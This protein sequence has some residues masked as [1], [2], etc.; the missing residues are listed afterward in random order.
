MAMIKEDQSMHENQSWGF[1]NFDNLSKSKEKLIV[2]SYG[3][4]RE[5]L[6]NKKRSWHSA[7]GSG[8]KVS[9]AK[10]NDG[11]SLELDH[12]M[13]IQIE[14]ERSKKMRNMFDN[15]HALLPQLPSKVD[16]STIVDEAVNYI[17]SLKETLEKLKRQKL[18]KLQSVST[19][20]YD[21]SMINS[22]RCPI[23]SKELFID[24]QGS[25]NNLTNRIRNPNPS[26][27][28]IIS[29]PQQ[30]LAFQTWG[31]P[32]LV[33]NICGKVAQFCIFATRKPC[34]FTTII[35]VLEKLKIDV[36]SANIMCDGDG[37]R[38]M[39]LAHANRPTYQLTPESTSV[40][41]IYMLAAK[42]I[43]QWIS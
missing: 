5:P 12:E 29:I 13:H 41:E 26:N 30:P 36:I 3:Q 20:R 15:L 4:E 7:C 37:N 2:E 31:S 16:K 39:S 23:D 35:F 42:E 24:D 14:R 17:Q 1:S 22:Q 43:I 40:E 6:M 32:N 19:F 38:Y 21:P 11:K 10:E 8:K 25:F 18:E 34:M 27:S 33:L 9:D 28:T